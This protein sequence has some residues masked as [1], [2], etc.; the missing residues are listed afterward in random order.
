MT[1]FITESICM[2]EIYKTRGKYF[3]M[4]VWINQT[5]EYIITRAIMCATVAVVA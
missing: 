5:T 2:A 3:H 1:S 4:R